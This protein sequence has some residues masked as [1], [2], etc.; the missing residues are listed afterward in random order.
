MIGCEQSGLR[1]RRLQ[2]RGRLPCSACLAL[3]SRRFSASQTAELPRNHYT[4]AVLALAPARSRARPGFRQRRACA[5]LSLAALTRA[6]LERSDFAVRRLPL[7]FA[8][9]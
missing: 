9:K 5:P 6:A 2:L 8:L 3:T 4:P 7:I 1:G